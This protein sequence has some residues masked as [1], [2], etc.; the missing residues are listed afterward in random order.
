[1]VSKSVL[2]AVKAHDHEYPNPI[3]AG[4]AVGNALREKVRQRNESEGA[5]QHSQL[6]ARCESHN[7]KTHN[8][9]LSKGLAITTE[10]KQNAETRSANANQ[11]TQSTFE[12][13][14]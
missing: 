6:V 3:L 7:E 14:P 4:L 12:P 13:S 11:K 5:Q 9:E 1:M 10:K 8:E 2:A